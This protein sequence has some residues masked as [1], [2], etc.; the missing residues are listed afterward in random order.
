[1]KII[2]NEIF[3]VSSISNILEIS[4]IYDRTT[5]IKFYCEFCKKEY[6]GTIRE[7]LKK[8]NLYCKECNTKKTKLDKYGSASFNNSN[9]R[10][11][12]NL[13]K[14]GVSCI[15]NRDDV[16]KQTVQSLKDPKRSEKISKKLKSHNEI[17]WK[18]LQKRKNE[19]IIKKYGSLENFQKQKYEKFKKTCL[20]KY[21]IENIGALNA[22]KE[23]SSLQKYFYDERFFDSSYELKYYIYLKDHNIKFE[24]H[25]KD[26]FLYKRK[27][28][29]THRYYPDFLINGK[30][31][32]IKGDFWFD[33]T[34]NCLLNKKGEIDIEKTECLRKNSIEIKLKNDLKNEFEYIDLTYGKD[35]I[36][37]F[38]YNKEK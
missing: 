32:E 29:S 12:T 10:K 1:M 13:K 2:T 31:I 35:F 26:Y 16:R 21:G 9:K 4:K 28:G 38:K 20:K 33:K 7:T 5:H 22:E 18:N 24:Y 8:G 3:Y 36:K 27:D 19:T 25:N 17:Y 23:Y 15:F 11:N 6:I 30:Y 37:Q 14:Y 34:K